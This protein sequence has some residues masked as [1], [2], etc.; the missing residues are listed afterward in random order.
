MARET[1]LQGGARR[2]LTAQRGFGG[3]MMMALI[4]GLAATAGMFA[5]YRTDVVRTANERATADALAAAKMALIGYAVRRG[6]VAGNDRPGELPC[7]DTDGDGLENAPCRLAS[8]LFGRLP[9]KTLGIPDPKDGAGETPWYALSGNFRD[10]DSYPTG[11]SST[12]RMINSDRRGNLTVRGPDGSTVLTNEA[13]AVIFA[14]GG[15]VG[16]QNR[17]LTG[18]VSCA[19]FNLSLNARLCPTNYL[20]S[21]SGIVDLASL[22]G[23]FNVAAPTTGANDRLA[24]LTTTELIPALEMRVANELRALLEKYRLHST[25][26]CYPWADTWEYSGG[27]A[28]IGQNRGR[29]PSEPFPHEWGTGTI[30]PLPQWVAANDWH[31]LVWYSVSKQNT[32]GEGA[33]CRTCS[34]AMMQTV[35]GMPVSALFILPGVPADGL[36]RLTSSSRRDNINLYFDDAGNRDAANESLCPDT[37]EI[38]GTPGSGSRKGALACDQYTMPIEKKFNRDRLFIV[39]VGGPGVCISAAKALVDAAPCGWPNVSSACTSARESLDSCTCLDAARTLTRPPCVNTLN[40]GQCE[41]AV[42]RLAECKI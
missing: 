28:D 25:C 29:F 16:A 14:P 3:F 10:W 26:K 17:S 40:P 8:S 41:T 4:A 11:T 39:G 30:P 37:G 33:T 22:N 23:P 42:T 20:E 6:G 13:V 1:G 36:A 2:R 21:A 9:W 5:F 32:A 19:L 35:D 34:D 27:I 7:P 24:Y 15:P 38:G 18:T 12:A 31:N